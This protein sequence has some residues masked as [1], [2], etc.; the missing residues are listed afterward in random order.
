MPKLLTAFSVLITLSVTAGAIIQFPT[1][2]RSLLIDSAQASEGKYKCVQDPNGANYLLY[3][4]GNKVASVPTGHK[5][6]VAK[7]RQLCRI[8]ESNKASC[9][10]NGFGTSFNLYCDGKLV[11]RS[12]YSA[13]HCL[14]VSRRLCP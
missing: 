2:Q 3:C 1:I 13:R 11:K 12:L 9:K 8:D 7:A 14:N 5:G 4:G 6:C 10:P